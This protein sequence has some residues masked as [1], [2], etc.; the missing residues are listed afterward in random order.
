MI[1]KEDIIC[2]SSI[3]WGFIWQ[4]HQQIMQTLASQGHRV[5][6]VENTGIRSPRIKD[7]DRLKARMKNFWK[8]VYGIRRVHPNLYIYSP[9]LLPFPYSKVALALNSIIFWNSLRRWLKALSFHK[10]IVWT[11]IPTKLTQKMVKKID[12]KLLVYY[13]IDN[14]SES[15]KGA[16]KIRNDE[17]DLLRQ[18]DLVFATS[19]RLIEHCSQYHSEVSFF[20]FGVD[21]SHYLGKTFSSPPKDLETIPSPRMVYIGGIH[22]W[23][24]FRLIKELLVKLPN[25]SF[26]FIGPNQID[27]SDLKGFKNL[28]FIP[29]KAQ[30]ELA[31]YLYYADLCLIPYRI[32]P[33]TQS[34]YPTKLNEYLVMGKK[35]ISTPIREIQIFNQHY[36]NPVSVAHTPEEFAETIRNE[37]GKKT[38]FCPKFVEIAKTNSW[39]QR[40]GLMLSLIDQKVL[41]KEEAVEKNWSHRIKILYRSMTRKIAIASA[42]LILGYATFFHSKAPYYIAQPLK[43]ENPLIPADAVLAL[44][45]GV[46][47]SGLAGQG[48]QE[49]VETAVNLYQKGWVKKIIFSSGYVY[50]MKEAQVM[51]NLALAMGVP[52]TDISIEDRGGNTYD[53]IKYF[54]KFIQK[55]GLKKVIIVSSPYHMKR[56]QLVAKRH[57]PSDVSF[58][59][60]PVESSL[61]FDSLREHANLQ[62]LKAILHEYAAIAYYKFKKWI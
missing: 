43:I 24:D 54:S 22:Q 62:Q 39:E 35:I 9:L 23:I 17:I 53:S 4:G 56:T 45:G 41:K 6:Y 13:C 57:F 15:S 11:F 46:G 33:Y 37:L 55:E 5:L 51:K 3:D 14:L 61:F 34:V 12:P 19:H 48:Y 27:V 2:F 7:L 25:V 58:L 1:S 30:L 26:V 21:L 59:L 31:H 52:E 36:D 40:I 44:G 60:K 28:Y 50:L 32:T 29:Q 18:A 10:P 20:P 16:Q 42:C 38:T 47:E 8:G 49:R